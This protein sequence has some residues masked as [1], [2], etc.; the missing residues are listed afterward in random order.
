[1]LGGSVMDAVKNYEKLGQSVKELEQKKLARE[2]VTE[3]LRESQALYEKARIGYQ[4][5]DENGNLIEVNPAWLN[6][7]GY[8]REE[9]I[10]KSF[11]E[12]I[13]P[14]QKDQFNQ[15]FHRFKAV[16]EILGDEFEMAKKDGSFI[17]VS[18]TGK[19]GKDRHGEFQQTHCIFHDVTERKRSEEALRRSEMK[20]RLLAENATDVICVMNLE[21]FV[22]N[23]ISPSAQFVSGYTLEELMSMKVYDFLTPDSVEHMMKVLAQEIEKEKLGK[24]EP[25]QLEMEILRKDGTTVWMEASVRFHRDDNKQI[26][27]VLCVA[28]DISERKKTEDALRDREQ[29]YKAIFE[30]SLDFI[31][32]HDLEGNFIDI[33]P[34][35]LNLLGYDK[36]EIPT[37]NLLK[38]TNKEGLKKAAVDL[39]VILKEGSLIK[40]SEYRVK[41]KDGNF[42]YM[43]AKSSVIFLDGQPFGVLGTARDMTDRKRAEEA[44]RES[45]EQFRS[46]Y[47]TAPLAYII[48][49]KNTHITDWNK[50]AEE[51]FGWSKK[52]VVGLNFFKFLIPEKDRPQ[53]ENVVKNLMRGEL[54][55]QSINENLTKKGKTITC[56]W[57]NSILHDNHGNI[58]GAIS[59]GLDITDR[60]KAEEELRESEKKFKDLAELLPQFVYELDEK[61]FFTFVN[62]SGL[63]LSGYTQK[64]IDNGISGLEV[65]HPESV[66]KIAQDIIRVLK[67]E[68]LAGREYMIKRKDG[69]VV[70]ITT[71]SSPILQKDKVVGIRGVG[72]DISERIAAEEAL[73]ESEIKHKT[74]VNNIPGMIYRA[75][76]DWSAE[77]ISGSEA[78]CGYTNND[79]SSKESNW[80]S[81]IHHDDK[82]DVIK[83]G[84]ELTIEQKDI[85]QTYRI[86]TKSGDIRW[87][88]DRKTS[89]FSEEGKFLWIDGV[90]FDIT[91]R[92]QTGE[93]LKT[94]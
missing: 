17:L 59:L 36:E 57:N 7:L 44:L 52:E 71:Y 46:L 61:G 10:G 32:I 74:L 55:N 31:F 65:M 51:V 35:G 94:S 88:E 91:D 19:I 49:D 5:L 45:E 47:H 27:G 50:K 75:Y 33:N 22:F 62:R 8:S 6:I 26:A 92:I 83:G 40:P 16:S 24:A 54:L 1:M 25:Q 15:N 13:H 42:I 80:L 41:K 90:A 89:I 34:A 60:I 82:E 76:P 23:F 20:Y 28:R 53:V 78:I 85:V 37:L 21:L 69:T 4:S 11:S 70:P 87:I 18:F 72:V 84:S 63:S 48:W 79:L 12:F 64:D 30:N 73:K 81:I 3:A 56:E 43:E 2:R 29:K 14:E 58:I 77:I 67:G 38:L 39:K 66:E 9:V 93:V 86:K 68:T